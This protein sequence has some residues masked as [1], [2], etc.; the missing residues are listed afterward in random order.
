MAE[1]GGTPEVGWDVL[2]NEFIVLIVKSPVALFAL[3]G[4]FLMGYGISF[5]LFD[6]RKSAVKKSHYILHV[7]LG[8]GYAAVIFLGVNWDI[9]SRDI[10]A[11][12]ITD[13][14]PITL[15]VSLAIG[16]IIIFTWSIVKE[17]R[18]PIASEENVDD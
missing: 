5:V 12:A 10:T 11:E 7:F 8:S 16:F 2:A 3:V 13:R 18:S 14:I 17:V 1:S 9:I 6:Y 15:I 4:S